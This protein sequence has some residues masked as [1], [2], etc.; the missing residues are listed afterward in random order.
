MTGGNW[1]MR[2]ASILVLFGLY[3]SLS[4]S[5]VCGTPQQTQSSGP[6]ATVSIK[7]ELLFEVDPGMEIVKD[8]ERASSGGKHMALKARSKG[9]AVIIMDGKPGPEY[10]DVGM[11]ALSLN[12]EQLAYPAKRGKKWVLILDGKEQGPEFDDMGSTH[13]SPE[14]QRVTYRGRR[15][16]GWSVVIDGKEGPSYL[17]LGYG[18]FSPDGKRF[19]YTTPMGVVVDGNETPTGADVGVPIFSPDS[20]HLAFKVKTYDKPGFMIKERWYIWRDGKSGPH[21]EEIS[22]IGFS[23][24]SKRVAYAARRSK[25][26]Y[27]VLIDEEQGPKFEAIVAGPEFS[28]DGQHVAYIAWDNKKMVEVLD[29]KAVREIPSEKGM[30][31]VNSLKF[32]P[33]GKR[34]LYIVGRGGIAY[35]MAL[36][37]GRETR[38][39]RRLIVDG[40]EGKVYDV[41]DV[42]PEFSPDGRHVALAVRGV[43]KD[44]D[45]IVLDGQEG[46]SYDSITNLHF[47]S[48]DAVEYV[49]RTG[50]KYYRVTQAAQ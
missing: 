26:D 18:A 43:E 47:A 37:E 20:K 4:G 49:A 40:Q 45:M 36:Q 3:F 34:L 33:D 31:F 39:R 2:G 42:N 15:R 28:P 46:K 25:D 12:G 8:S 16:A 17:S 13:F 50:K 41:L 35:T 27:C 6:V 9:K 11:P 29:G 5:L 32:S 1:I 14:G 21:F 44:K 7:E 22:N 10:D 38:A 23:P 19:A 24:D 30:N 48:N